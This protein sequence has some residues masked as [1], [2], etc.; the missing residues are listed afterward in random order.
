MPRVRL[1]ETVF[2]DANQSL[3]QSRMRTED[4]VA[5][6]PDLDR[7]GYHSLEVWGGAT[8]EASLRHLNEDPWDRLR[9][10]KKVVKDTPLQ[11][12]LRGQNLVGYKSYPDDV[13]RLFVERAALAGVDIFRIYDGLNDLRNMVVP[14]KAAKVAGRHVQGAICYTLSPV[15]TVRAFAAMARELADLGCDSICVKDMAG[16]ISPT[17]AGRVVGAVR[18]AVDLPVAFH[19]HCTSG[20]AP[21]ACTA[22]IEAGAEIVDTAISPFAWGASQPPTE[23]IVAA[24][25]GTRRDTGLDLALLSQVKVHFETLAEKYA[26]RFEP[27]SQRTDTDVSTYQVPAWM[28][29]RLRGELAAKNAGKLYGEVLAEIPRVRAEMGYPPLVTPAS[30]VVGAQ[31]MANV[32]A[33]ER[34][35]DVLPETRDYFLGL[36][37]QPPGPLDAHVRE[38][39]LGSEEP[40]TVRPA[41]LLDPALDRGRKDLRKAGVKT[42]SPD[43]LLTFVLFP[44]AGLRFLR[45]EGGDERPDKRRAKEREA[46]ATPA[47]A[48]G[49]AHAGEYLV[50]VDGEAFTVRVTP[51][52]A[53]AIGSVPAAGGGAP[54]GAAPAGSGAAPAAAAGHAGAVSAP[55][56]GLLLKVA[57][58]T[59]DTVK[60]GQ[61][62]AV[63]EAMKMQNDLTATRAGTVKDVYAKEGDVVTP[64]QVL[65]V[66]E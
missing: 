39:A 41:D 57:V 49:A 21:Q 9:Q 13:V 40:I 18:K 58:A 5:V 36:F 51:T 38:L 11:M 30:Q 22:A 20:M 50:E 16:L 53:T 47:S 29:T 32:L 12:L 23:S 1:T 8:F 55:M 15:H 44:V 37:G 60:L 62:L 42:E 17:E 7:V 48:G 35:A 61:T 56:Q 26:D 54:S 64:G 45:G 14:I 65:M 46:S 4:M 43:D 10:L 19:S 34:Y 66:I 52:G 27:H 31:A 63:L 24:L 33:G 28:L 59:G 6:A 3:I 25:A 2:R